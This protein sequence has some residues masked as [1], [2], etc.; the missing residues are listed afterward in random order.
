[1]KNDHRWRL[2]GFPGI[3]DMSCVKHEERYFS[4]SDSFYVMAGKRRLI[5]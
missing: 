5:I 4:V 1:M 3:I 2:R